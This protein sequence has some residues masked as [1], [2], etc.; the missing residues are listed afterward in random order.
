MSLKHTVRLQEKDPGFVFI[1]FDQKKQKQFYTKVV[2][3]FWQNFDDGIEMLF[4]V[5]NFFKLSM[6]ELYVLYAEGEN[7]RTFIAQ[8]VFSDT[9]MLF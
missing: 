2:S 5:L 6:G 8:N 3:I 4:F 7:L 1:D 9:K